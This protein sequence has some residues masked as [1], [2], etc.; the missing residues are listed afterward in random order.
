M[1]NTE[2]EL[3]AENLFKLS[4]DVRARRPSDT[5]KDFNKRLIASFRANGGR[6]PGE[7]SH[8]PLILITMTGRKS[9]DKRTV[10]LA[11]VEM[12]DR[13]FIIASRGGGKEHPLWYGNILADPNVTVEIRSDIYLARATPLPEEERDRIFGLIADVNPTFADYQS[14]TSRKIPVVELCRIDSP[15]V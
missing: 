10:P 15:K 6:V 4:E 13:L 12:E 7:L 8:V 5:T 2:T 14:R 11:Y 1:S 3:T 9:G